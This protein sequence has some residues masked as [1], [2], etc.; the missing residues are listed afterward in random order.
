MKSKN[1][2]KTIPALF[3]LLAMTVSCKKSN[4]TNATVMTEEEAAEVIALSVSGNTEALADQVV[5]I[6]TAANTYGSTCAYSKDTTVTRTNSTGLY[7]WNY[8]FNWKWNVVCTA[9]IPNSMTANYKMKG[10]YDTP[11]MGSNDSS[12]ANLAV[13][14]L[15]IGAQYT[16]NGTYTREGSQVSKIRN[17][18][19]FS[20]KVLLNLSN[21]KVS[22]ATGQ[23]DA[24]T[25]T[26]SITGSTSA[27][28]SFSYG[29][30]ISFTGSKTAVITL[31]NGNVYPVSW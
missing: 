20:S 18:N 21:L 17:Q 26:A 22:K 7:T 4:D 6:A 9:G 1:L 5:E 13:T 24:G 10:T 11:R 29:G 14:N 25:A 2:L 27:G 8:L 12:S 31:N 3:F 15:L 16:Y 23:I 28:N 19:S 30:N